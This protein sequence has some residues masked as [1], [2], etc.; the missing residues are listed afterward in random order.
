MWLVNSR[1]KHMREVKDPHDPRYGLI[2][3]GGMEVL[4]V[5][6]GMHMYYMNAFAILGLREAADAA[7]SL[8]RAED[9]QLFAAQAAELTDSLHK[10]FAST[11]K[12]NGLYEGNLWFGVEPEGVG[13]YGFWAHCCLLWPCRALDPHDPMLSATWR[14]MEQMSQ[15]WG[16]GLFSESQGGYWPYIGV[17]WALSYILRGEPDRTLDYFCAYVDKAGGT[18]SWGEG[19]GYVMAGGDQ[20]H[21]WADGQY[22]NLFRH[23]FVMEDGS[24]LLVT[25]ALFRRWHQGDKPVIVRGLPTHFGDVDLRIQPT[26]RGDQLSYTIKITPQGDQKQRELSRI[27]LYPRTPTGRAIASA[28]IDGKPA[29]G[30]TDTALVISKPPRDREIRV[31]VRTAQ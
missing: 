22:V 30:F 31:T 14:K 3:P 25:P 18:L 27:V 7:Q 6:K 1:Q 15:A 5:G 4:E 2:E 19:Y 16:G 12:R 10:S 9:Y 11:F 24:T 23:L 13:M 29:S 28:S 20:P 8:G 26:P 17:D 21:F